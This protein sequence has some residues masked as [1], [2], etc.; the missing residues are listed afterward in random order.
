[1]TTPPLALAAA[2]YGI[3][4]TQLIP[5]R[6]GHFTHV[7]HFARDGRDYV[8]RLTPPD[9]SV[10]LKAQ[11][12]V[13]AWMGFLAAHGASVPASLA[14]VNG[15]LVEIVPS[16][17]GEW[18]VTAQIRAQGVLAEE[19]SLEQWDAE[20]FHALG[21]TAGKLHAVACVYF[22]IAE[23]RPPLWDESTSLFNV[24]VLKHAWLAEKR[25]RVMES[26]RKLPVEAE[27]FGLIHADFHFGNLFVDV[28]SR[29]IT[30]F[31]FD[32]CATGWFVM[33]IALQL[34][35][36][37][38]LYAEKQR[39]AFAEHFLKNFLS[40]YVEEKALPGHWIE[41]LP[42]FLKLLEINVY[43]RVADS[44]PEHADAWVQRFMPGRKERIECN[45][46]YIELDFAA[47][48]KVNY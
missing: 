35:D 46:P 34:F 9:E 2:L 47:F 28:S 22:P 41:Q 6:G 37:L 45:E 27:T 16:V 19:L 14:S 12:S 7:Y 4:E 29:N 18:L 20:L 31:D 38:V 21:K 36:I 24:P 40:G 44:Y 13:L 33:D 42:L 3:S 43:D 10:D 17:E 26:I 5:L 15:K 32:D 48:A 25:S 1:M 11:Q 8:L 39:A 30:V 23:L